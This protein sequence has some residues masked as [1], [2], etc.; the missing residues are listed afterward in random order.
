MW[1]HGERT[2]GAAKM[3]YRISSA[4]LISTST[5]KGY[6]MVECVKRA[7]EHVNSVVNVVTIISGVFFA[8]KA[9]GLQTTLHT[10]TRIF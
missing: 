7:M 9:K 1:R 8:D 4:A 10:H 5:N 2:F 3:D 6:E